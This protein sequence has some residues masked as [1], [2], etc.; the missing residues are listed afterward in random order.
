MWKLFEGMSLKMMSRNAYILRFSA[1]I[2]S[3][4][5][6]ELIRKRHVT[7]VEKKNHT[8]NQSMRE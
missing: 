1:S 6:A 8:V 7:V 5:P 3:M 2:R 4:T